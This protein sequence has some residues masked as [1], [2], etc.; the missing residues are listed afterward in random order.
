M[1][2][3]KFFYG[4]FTLL[5][6]LLGSVSAQKSMPV[7]MQEL[8]DKM[9]EAQ[10]GPRKIRLAILSL[11]P[12]GDSQSLSESKFGAYF[13]ESLISALADKSENFRLFE[14]SRLDAVLSELALGQSGLL[15]PKEAVRLGELAPIDAVFSGTYSELKSTVA[16]NTRLIDAVSGEILMT[17]SVEMLKDE[18]L[19]SLF[20]ADKLNKDVDLCGQ[21]QDKLRN[22]LNDLSNSEM[23]SKMVNFAISIPFD[24]E[25]GKIHFEVISRLTRYKI[26]SKAYH[27][28]LLKTLK[29]IDFPQNDERGITIL[30]FFGNDKTIDDTEWDTGYAAAKKVSGFTLS[31]YLRALLLPDVQNDDQIVLKRA[32]IVMNDAANAK[33]G[34][35]V[36]LDV[37]TVFFA[38]MRAVNYNYA[39]DNRY[40]FPLFA[41]YKEQLDYS[42]KKGKEILSLLQNMYWRENDSGKRDR[43]LEWLIAYFNNIEINDKSAEDLYSF[44]KSLPTKGRGNYAADD[45]PAPENHVITFNEKCATALCNGLD[46]ARF[47]SQ[48]EERQDYA[49]INQLNCGSLP[50][51]KDLIEQIDSDNQNIQ[52]RAAEM[53]ALIGK[54]AAPAETKMIEVLSASLINKSEYS[55]AVRQEALKTLGNIKTNRKDGIESVAAHLSSLEYMIPDFASDA[56][57]AIGRAAVPTLID[58]LSDTAG[59]VQYRAA[60]ILGRIGKDALSAKSELEKLQKTTRS[61]DIKN[62]AYQAV[63]AITR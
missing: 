17:Y 34:L 29:G 30:R 55:R 53:I 50:S 28:F 3:L 60:V 54:K 26:E 10:P 24:M 27:N 52:E 25:C 11:V 59:S 18:Q 14:R 63:K 47:R 15:D 35:P 38:M 41:D 22:L 57:V 58:K 23:I 33:I 44:A 32:E 40:C 56:L 21:Q 39:K 12:A 42:D 9:D 16:V 19:E 2:Y 13:T 36:S 43:V 62:A 31:S 1:R 37:H 6:F 46:A 5:L 48:T 51:I 4:A 45:I 61:P 7:I 8:V 20:T 49:L